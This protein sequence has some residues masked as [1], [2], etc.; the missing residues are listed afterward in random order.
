MKKLLIGLASLMMASSMTAIAISR[1]E[2]KGVKAATGDD[3]FFRG[4]TNE[5]GTTPFYENGAPL[6]LE[7]A[8]DA[9]F[10]VTPNND[11]WVGELNTATGDAV[12]QG[13]IVVPGS[14]QNI[15]V[16]KAGTYALSV[17]G[18]ALYVDYGIFYS[19]GTGNSWNPAPA[20]Y[21]GHPAVTVNAGPST[22]TLAKDEQ[23][24]LIN[25]NWDH[26]VFG[27]SNLRD[28]DFYGSFST[29]GGNNIICSIAGTYDISISMTN[30]EWTFRAVPSGVDPDDTAYVYV[31]DKYGT[32]LHSN[33]HASTSDS[34]GRTMGHP[35][36]TMETYEGTNHM[37]K[38][39]FWVG[40][41][42]VYFN[43]DG[44][45][46]ISYPVKGV[47]SKAGKCLILDGNVDGEGKWNS[48]TWV[49][50]ATA[51]FIENCLHFA[52]Y[53]EAELG[54]GDCI[55]QGWYST[56]S[57][58]YAALSEEVK[59]EVC[60]LPYVVERLQ[61][62]AI[63]NGKTFTITDGVGSFGAYRVDRPDYLEEGAN[64]SALIFASSIAIIALAGF[65]FLRRKK[66]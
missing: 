20:A 50:P 65:F 6:I 9:E 38:Q 7:M 54:Q 45:R 41:E 35:G 32:L 19:S 16:N 62:W 60:S 42:S 58:S 21:T 34:R 55:S 11:N 61:K 14:A 15:K 30:R 8:K 56:A 63:A 18:G 3:Y 37:Y 22:F 12:S 46:S 39:E 51:K 17:K 5:W 24:K 25:D 66:A 43:N 64:A 4:T 2:P 23:L 48:S 26:G 1:A 10:K 33:H 28:G 40:M 31:L 52:N 13:D 36:A 59:A 53:G 49:K 44:T 29:N 57:S 47:D 27:Y